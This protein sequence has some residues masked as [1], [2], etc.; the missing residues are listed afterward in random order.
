V[1]ISD[2][3]IGRKMRKD[4]IVEWDSDR[5]KERGDGLQRRME[6]LCLFLFFR[7]RDELA[8]T[9]DVM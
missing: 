9:Y 1:L 8:A 2:R 6:R 7:K 5:N 3:E 4:D